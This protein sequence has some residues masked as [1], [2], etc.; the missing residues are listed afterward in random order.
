MN[1]IHYTLAVVILCLPLVRAQ[2]QAI[3]D[4][5]NIHFGSLGGYVRAAGRNVGLARAKVMVRR[6][7]GGFG[8]FYFNSA[9]GH[10][11]R[12]ELRY[13]L[14]GRYSVEVDR[15]SLSRSRRPS[16]RTIHFVEITGDHRSTVELI[17]TAD[18]AARRRRQ[19]I[20]LYR[21]RSKM[22]RN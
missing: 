10:D 15:R 8:N 11:G 22:R 6:V 13:L 7:D 18:V 19:R 4:N 2:G 3:A 17:L 20:A 21:G 12:F 5:D 1:I 9:S 16:V 14:P